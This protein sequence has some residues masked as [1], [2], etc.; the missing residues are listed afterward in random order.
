MYY[1]LNEN[2][3]RF[4][5]VDIPEKAVDFLSPTEYPPSR[6]VINIPSC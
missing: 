2:E 6:F 3:E 1:P 5:C 4:L